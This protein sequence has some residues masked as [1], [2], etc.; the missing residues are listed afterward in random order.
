MSVIN[1]VSAESTGSTSYMLTHEEEWPGVEAWL[2]DQLNGIERFTRL[3]TE[4][5]MSERTAL[6]YVIAL[7][8]IEDYTERLS[9]LGRLGLR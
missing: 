8:K 4:Q 1:E 2:A 3:I 7:T 5:G 6:F 9:Y